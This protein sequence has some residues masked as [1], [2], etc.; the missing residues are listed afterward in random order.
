[1]KKCLLLLL[2]GVI[3]S[4]LSYAQQLP[5]GTCGIVC[6][7]DAAGNRLKRVYFCNNGTDPYPSRRVP[8]DTLNKPQITEE[9]QM[10]DALYPNPTTGRFFVMFSKELKNASVVLM[11]MSGKVVQQMV[12]NGY[13]LSFDLSNMASGTY[14]VRIEDEG[15]IITKKVI[16]Q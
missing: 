12:G 16:K 5:L 9:V 3:M 6:T 1:M 2:F 13:R 11:D 8:N 14:I 10:I 15:L 7:Y 4:F